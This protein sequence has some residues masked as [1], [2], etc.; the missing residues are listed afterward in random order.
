MSSSVSKS[1]ILGIPFD[2]VDYAS[3]FATVEEWRHQGRRSWLAITNPHSVMTCHRD[4]AMWDATVEAGMVLP[5]GVGITLAARI[6]GYPH[7]GRVTGPTL[8]LRLCDWGREKGYRHFFYG[9]APGVAEELAARLTERFPGLQVAG[10]YCPPFRP[11]APEE[12]EE[13]VRLINAA[14]PDIVW[15]GLGAPKQEKWI[16]KHRDRLMA[17]VCVGVGAAFDFHSGR[18]PWAPAWIRR[19]GLEWGIRLV[20]EPRRMWRRNVDSVLFLARVLGA[21]LGRG[22]S[23]RPP[24]SP[25]SE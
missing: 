5:D 17:P 20:L 23:S 22:K 14:C 8:M 19:A 6:L 16:A 13:V 2:L 1:E 4:P 10:T 21:K 25:D 9:G 12:D 3:V 24:S 7:R 15:V 18:V 11:L